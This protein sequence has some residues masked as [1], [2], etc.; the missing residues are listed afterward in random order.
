VLAGLRQEPGDNAAQ[1]AALVS[2]TLLN[3]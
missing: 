1:M 3:Q 2:R